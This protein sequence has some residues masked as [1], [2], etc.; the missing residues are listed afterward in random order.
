MKPA[1]CDPPLDARPAQP[2]PA[3]LLG[4]DDTVLPRSKR[5]YSGHA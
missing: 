3:H 1:G 4:G 5:R 2:Q